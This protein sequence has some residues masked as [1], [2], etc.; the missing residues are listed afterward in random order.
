MPASLAKRP[1]KKA[2]LLESSDDNYLAGFANLAHVAFLDIVDLDGLHKIASCLRASSK[3]LRSLT[4]SLSWDIA[5]KARKSSTSANN[6]PPPA[7][8]DL[9]VDD[10]DELSLDPGPPPPPS[11]PVN[12][13]E[14][15]RDRLAQEDIL[16]KIFDLEAVAAEGKKIETDLAL[17]LDSLKPA[18]TDLGDADFSFLTD[19]ARFL[20][21]FMVAKDRGKKEDMRRMLKPL[22]N[23]TKELEKVPTSGSEHIMSAVPSNLSSAG[24]ASGSNLVEWSNPA[25]VDSIVPDSA[26][27]PGP[28]PVAPM[29]IPPAIPPGTPFSPA[30]VALLKKHVCRFS[31]ETVVVLLTGGKFS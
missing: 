12:A 10:S 16:A 4:L 24:P 29:A 15:R 8:D 11:Q 28:A 26:S 7:D 17:S 5:S 31:L 18:I 14:V 22:Y 2:K 3:S 25:T 23:K 9:S 27:N 13:A 20:T 30:E 6:P 19:L 21:A 1:P